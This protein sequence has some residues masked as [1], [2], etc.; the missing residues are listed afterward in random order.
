MKKVIMYI[1]MAVAITGVGLAALVSY[2][3]NSVGTT[4][5]VS[6]PLELEAMTTTDLTAFG[7]ESRT[8]VYKVTNKADA[9]IPGLLELAVYNENGV[10]CQD[11]DEITV[12]SVSILSS[13]SGSDANN[14]MVEASQTYTSL[15]ATNVN[16]IYTFVPNAVGLYNTTA[17]VM[18]D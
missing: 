13:C 4:V 9:Q 12:D 16:V 3:S 6:S 11:F 7:G 14:I 5:T 10:S 1:I 17:Q 15:S 18:A 8:V 2:L